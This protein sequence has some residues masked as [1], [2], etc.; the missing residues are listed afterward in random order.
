M[1]FYWRYGIVIYVCKTVFAVRSKRSCL[2]LH[3]MECKPLLLVVFK[4]Y[5]VITHLII[6]TR[7]GWGGQESV[8]FFL[9]IF[10]PGVCNF[11][12]LSPISWSVYYTT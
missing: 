4:S 12:A 8:T 10:D 2:D 11:A 1:Q 6:F 9:V 3:V 5:L 7:K